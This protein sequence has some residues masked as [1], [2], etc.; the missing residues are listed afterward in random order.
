MKAF[1]QSKSSLVVLSLFL[2]SLAMSFA[3]CVVT[4]RPA[5]QTR[6]VVVKQ[7]RHPH[8]MPPG[9]AKKQHGHPGKR[10]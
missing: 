10:H 5:Y 3:S 2:T 8:G 4:A 9:Q 6:T 7:K 1:I